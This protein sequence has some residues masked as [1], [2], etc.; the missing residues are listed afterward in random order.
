MRKKYNLFFIHYLEQSTKQR[1]WIQSCLVR[2]GEG[3]GK[4]VRQVEERER[5]TRFVCSAVICL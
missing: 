2:Q 1:L 5:I 4:V 3:G